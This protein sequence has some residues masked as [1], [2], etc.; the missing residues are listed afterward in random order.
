MAIPSYS[1]NDGT[2]AAYCRSHEQRQ[3]ADTAYKLGLVCAIVL[4]LLT[5]L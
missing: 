2:C 4:L 3:I 5:T 1:E